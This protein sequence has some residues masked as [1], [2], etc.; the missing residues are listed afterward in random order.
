MFDVLVEDLTPIELEAGASQRYM[1]LYLLQKRS[2]VDL[3][4]RSKTAG[5]GTVTRFDSGSQRLAVCLI[6]EILR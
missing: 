6:D 4:K 1:S 3:R 5:V 2:L